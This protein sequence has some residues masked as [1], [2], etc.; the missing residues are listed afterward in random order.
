ML[1]MPQSKVYIPLEVIV[2]HLLA[3]GLEER[4]HEACGLIIPEVDQAP[5]NWVK[6]MIN[7]AENPFNSYRLDPATIQQLTEDLGRDNPAWDNVIVWH[8]HPSGHVGP[9]D[10][11][12]KERIDG[13]KYLVVAIPTGEA[14]FF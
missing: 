6:K 11:D 12:I 2:P 9:S 14:T 4:P 13:L 3:V 10:L 7:R 8:T 1:H 5:I